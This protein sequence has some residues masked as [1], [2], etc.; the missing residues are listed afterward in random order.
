MQNSNRSKE[1]RTQM[2][3]EGCIN[4]LSNIEGINKKFTDHILD[5]GNQKE[6]CFHIKP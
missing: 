3:I 1:Q 6:I 5:N 4:H 2:C